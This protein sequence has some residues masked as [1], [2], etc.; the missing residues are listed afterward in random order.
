[1]EILCRERKGRHK[2]QLYGKRGSKRGTCVST[3]LEWMSGRMRDFLLRRRIDKCYV[4]L[5]QRQQ[6][7]QIGI[8]C[9]LNLLEANSIQGKVVLMITDNYLIA[10]QMNLAL[11]TYHIDKYDTCCHDP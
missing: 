5:L 1:M 7:F 3:Q 11:L 9:T 10:K 2:V 4:V 8:S 6:H